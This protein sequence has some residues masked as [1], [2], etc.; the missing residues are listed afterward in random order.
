MKY[1]LFILCLQSIV[2][3]SKDVDK[4]NIDTSIK[5]N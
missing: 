3:R 2:Y 4:I 5:K 1:I